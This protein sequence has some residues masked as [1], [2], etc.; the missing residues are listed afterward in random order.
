MKKSDLHRVFHFRF[1]T[2]VAAGIPSLTSRDFP[3]HCTNHYKS[4][5]KRPTFHNLLPAAFDL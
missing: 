5:V 1:F 4:L 2:F 3:T